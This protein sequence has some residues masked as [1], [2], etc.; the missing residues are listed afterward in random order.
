MRLQNLKDVRERLLGYKLSSVARLTSLS[1]ERLQA[2]EAGD[3]PDFYELSL[4]ARVYGIDIEKLVEQP[5]HLAPGDGI[6]LLTSMDEFKEID[7]VTRARVVAAANAARDLVTLFELKH[8]ESPRVRF[9][10]ERPRLSLDQREKNALP[11]QQ[12]TALARQLRQQYSLSTNPIASMR[13][14]VRDAFPDLFVLYAALGPHGPAGL[15]FADPLRGPVIVL[16]TQ[17]KN[18]NPCVRRFSLAHELCHLL[19]DWNGRESLASISGYFNERGLDRERR[20]NAFA[21]RFLCPP[22]VL[23]RLSDPT[24]TDG[25]RARAKYGLPYAA[26]RKY[27][28]N[29]RSIE[30]PR[31][32]ERGVAASWSRAE[33]P[34]NVANFPLEEVPTERR[35]S[36]A[37]LAAELYSDG[38]IGRDEFADMMGV[39][40]AEEV[41][42]VLDFFALDW[43][44]ERV[45][46][47]A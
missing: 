37:E 5:I 20:A 29:E 14:F 10:Q 40:P 41:E 26:W 44:D 4:L 17:G 7:D 46:A 33:E 1:L 11:H 6:E 38:R 3:E 34:D 32:P 19:I 35:N 24:G 2:I 8:G 18:E 12:G 39:T 43:P 13:D 42:R 23:Q 45:A 31:S 25:R 16:N 27:L 22:S 30:L 21:V 28:R 36:I 47:E 9:L 15:G